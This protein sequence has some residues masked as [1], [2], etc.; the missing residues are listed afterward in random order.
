MAVVYIH[1]EET[2]KY[3]KKTEDVACE[4]ELYFDHVSPARK[5][6][7][8][9]SAMAYELKQVGIRSQKWREGFNSSR[10]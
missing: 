10:R 9:D 2:S 7:T 1:W 5:I 4:L 3:V 6:I 8:Q